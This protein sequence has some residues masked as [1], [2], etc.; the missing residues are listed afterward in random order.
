MKPCMC[1]LQVLILFLLTL[2]HAQWMHLPR[3]FVH[4]KVASRLDPSGYEGYAYVDNTRAY[5][6]AFLTQNNSKIV[7]YY[8]TSM[9]GN[10]QTFI[11]GSPKCEGIITPLPQVLL[12]LLSNPMLVLANQEVVPVKEREILD[13]QLFAQNCISNSSLNVIRLHDQTPLVVC[14]N[15]LFIAEKFTAHFIRMEIA[16]GQQLLHSFVENLELNCKIKD[17]KLNSPHMSNPHHLDDDDDGE[18]DLL[19]FMK[20]EKCCPFSNIRHHRN[21]NNIIRRGRAVS[22]DATKRCVFLHGVGQYLVEKGPISDQFVQYW[23]NVHK[24]TPQCKE[25]LFIKEET[26]G[27][28]WNDVELQRAYCDVAL[29][30]NST[31]MM[32]RDTV[33][34]VHSMGNLV[35]SAAI[36]N[37]FCDIDVNT[38]SWYQ[39]MGPFGGTKAVVRLE[40]VCEG[41]ESGKWPV[42]KAKLYRYVADKGGYCVAGTNHS[43]P[44]YLTLVPSYCTQITQ[45]CI[46]D[47]YKI[48][49]SRIKGSMCGISA[50][51]LTSVYSAALKILSEIVDFGESSDGLVPI[52]SCQR[53]SQDRTFTSNYR[54]A[55]YAVAAN[56][57][58]GTCRNGDSYFSDAASPCSYYKDKV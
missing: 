33:L 37:G 39:L 2:V 23:G 27:R 18:Q 36:K 53:A 20:F 19:W 57:A 13:T 6:E 42:S 34:F 56:H 16:H 4:T 50:Y 21:C 38:T 3:Y 9:G 28:G 54:D 5:V 58:D 46:D 10:A 47:L 17:L 48:A 14:D 52:S 51:G 32:I 45:E 40:E 41:S 7:Y 43:Y 30:K 15:N 44:S 25:R 24:Y 49:S 12:S 35:L 31:D 22:T 29:N 26:K 8:N 11:M 1:I 55:W